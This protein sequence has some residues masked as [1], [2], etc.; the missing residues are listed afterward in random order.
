MIISSSSRELDYVL[1]ARQQPIKSSII[2]HQFLRKLMRHWRRFLQGLQDRVLLPLFFFFI[3][4]S[5]CSVFS[6]L[7]RLRTV[8]I[9]RLDSIARQKPNRTEATSG[10]AEEH[11]TLLA[12]LVRTHG[13]F[14]SFT[15]E[16]SRAEPSSYA[17]GSSSASDDRKRSQT[18]RQ[19]VKDIFM[20][21]RK[22]GKV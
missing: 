5:G 6:V 9:L 10:Q 20:C 21:F 19:F 22:E 18:T 16:L 2:P 11:G 4:F 1:P 13:R 15:P 14:W 3:L 17:R 8:G 7:Q 12:Y